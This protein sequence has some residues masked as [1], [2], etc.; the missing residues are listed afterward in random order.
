[1]MLSY[2]TS[3]ARAVP[4]LIVWSLIRWI[5]TP[6]RSFKWLWII[7]ILVGFCVL[8][9]NWSTG[10]VAIQIVTIRVPVVTPGRAGPY[11]PW[12][13]TVSVP[14]GAIVFLLWRGA[15]VRKASEQDRNRQSQS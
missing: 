4:V 12:T 13:L 15:L 7:F 11:A 1:M 2:H 8:S 3:P 9:L 5:K 14:L 10:E 6:M